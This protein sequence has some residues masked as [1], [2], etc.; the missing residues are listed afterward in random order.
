MKRNIHLAFICLAIM[1]AFG[2]CNL[3]SAK[4]TTE[5]A[6]CVK[7]SS[8]ACCSEATKAC[9][10]N[11]LKIVATVTIKDAADKDAIEQALF[12]VVDGT[13]T[14]EGNISYELHQDINNPLVYV[15]IEVWKSQ[16]AIDIH[17]A[18]EHFKT[19][20]TAVDG[21]VDM[22]VNTVKKVK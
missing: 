21:K 1:L 11:A 9:C 3:K 13:R 14:E 5:E 6:C 19:F 10:E 12:A 18:T 8:A 2:A 17:G 22:A 16:E 4:N 20:A 15:F 7:E